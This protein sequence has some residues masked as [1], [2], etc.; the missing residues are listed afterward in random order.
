MVI[1]TTSAQ[2]LVTFVHVEPGATTE[3]NLGGKGR[4]VVGKLRAANIAQPNDWQ[5]DVQRLTSESSWPPFGPP[6]KR[7][8]FSSEKEFFASQQQWY[9]RSR[10]FWLSEAGM[11]AR[12]AACEYAAIFEPDGSFRINDVLP[13]MYRFD[14]RITDPTDPRGF[15]FAKSIV[16]LTKEITVDEGDAGNASESLDLGVL[17]VTA[18]EK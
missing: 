8:N 9:E 3:V 4:Q 6:V 16:S 18:N 13:G 7:E 1:P 10:E 15:P 2:T 5:R 14:I 12:A 11:A 17:E